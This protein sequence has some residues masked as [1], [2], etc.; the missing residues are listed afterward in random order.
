MNERHFGTERLISKQ[1]GRFKQ[2]GRMAS[3]LTMLVIATPSIEAA[4][5]D[6]EPTEDT[7]EKIEFSIEQVQESYEELYNSV[8]DHGIVDSLNTRI[9]HLVIERGG[10]TVHVKAILNKDE[11]GFKHVSIATDDY[12]NVMID[13]DADGSIDRQVTSLTEDPVTF[14]GL[15][16]GQELTNPF[17]EMSDEGLE[18]FV[19]AL[20]DDDL[21]ELRMDF[22]SDEEGN[23]FTQPTVVGMDSA[24]GK[25]N[26]LETQYQPIP[27]ED[28]YFQGQESLH[29][30][31]SLANNLMKNAQ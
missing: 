6:T 16:E 9:R 31:V 15:L 17:K 30:S 25:T 2:F 18:G 12:R 10:D 7:K 24:S 29:Y 13:M 19:E 20:E 21:A 23:H 1:A 4:A 28:G 3:L 22:L 11:S 27:S 5:N 26:H 8:M 14:T